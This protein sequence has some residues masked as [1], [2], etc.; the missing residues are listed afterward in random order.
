M[1]RQAVYRLAGAALAAVALAGCPAA[2]RPE[3]PAPAAPAPAP[4]APAPAPA[5]PAPAAPAPAPN[6][7]AARADALAKL[8]TSVPGVRAAWV[9]VSGDTA[10]VGID[11]EGP[12]RAPA[13]N[14]A[15]ER[16]VARALETSP[17]GIRRALVSTRP[18]VLQSIQN[19]AE[20]IRAGQPLERFAS[21][22]SKLAAELAP[23]T[24]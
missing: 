5:A 13:E 19:I 12:H 2:R 22:I 10:Y 1:R 17:H 6:P 9:V 20:G 4:A 14:R 11:A 8:A 24:R 23:T 21:E 3:A 16:A 15:L 7:E 18:E